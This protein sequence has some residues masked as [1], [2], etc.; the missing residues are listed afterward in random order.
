MKYSRK[1]IL[2][3]ER[4]Q[5]LVEFAL[6]FPLLLLVLLALI[7]FG[8]LL[9]I[10]S[11]TL[12]ASREAV[13]YGSAAGDIGGG[14]PHYQDCAGIRSA[15]RRVGNMAGISDANITISYDHGPNTTVFSTT[16]PAPTEVKL[17]DRMIIRV[18]ATYQPIVPIVNVPAFPISAQSFRTILK[19]VIIKG[20]PEDP[21]PTNTDTP[22]PPTDTPTPTPTSTP[23]PTPTST[24]TPTDTPSDMPTSTST[25]SPTATETLTPTPTSTS[26]PTPTATP[27]CNLQ[28]GALSFGSRSINQSEYGVL[29][30][31][32]IN[33]TN[34]DSVILQVLDIE[35]PAS[36]PGRKLVA[37]EMDAQ[38]IWS[39]SNGIFGGF[40]GYYGVCYTILEGNWT[41]GYSSYRTIAA[42]GNKTIG[43]V[44]SRVLA[45]GNYTMTATFE[46]LTT[47]G[48]CTVGASAFY[49]AP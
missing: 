38:T 36:S 28:S 1:Q 29:S 20:T 43:V 25:P 12:S 48:R 17:G 19:D 37:V 22:L 49:T 26:T 35:W 15:A 34:N 47:H 39:D 30:W 13:R 16:C 8:R 24:P 31:N 46:N 3:Q 9:F 21:Y 14:T 42:A 41:Q 44:F 7:E 10:Y 32:V 11:L 18:V 33:L 23:T 27:F 5:G 40:C 45:S 4:A 6:I 2:H